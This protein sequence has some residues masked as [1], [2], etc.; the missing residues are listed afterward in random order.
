MD[1]TGM[2]PLEEAPGESI[3]LP[4]EEGAAATGEE[5]IT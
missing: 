2:N 1:S 4:E 5:E 3:T